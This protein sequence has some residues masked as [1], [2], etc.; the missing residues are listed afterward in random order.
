MNSYSKLFESVE[1]S[2]TPDKSDSQKGSGTTGNTIEPDEE[3][4]Y[5]DKLQWIAKTS[6]DLYKKVGN[7]IKDT[8]KGR[9]FCIEELLRTLKD[10]LDK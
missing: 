3:S 4:P 1:N 9:I 8:A 7:N 5:R 6:E 10:E 2:E